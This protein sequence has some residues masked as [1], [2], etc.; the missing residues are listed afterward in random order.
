MIKLETPITKY[1]ITLRLVAESDAPFIVAIRNDERKKSFISKSCPDVDS[2]VQWI[3]DYKKRE[4]A[5]NE[6]YFI[7]EDETGEP[8]ATYRGYKISDDVVGGGSW[9]TKPDYEKWINA[10]KLDVLI[11]ELVFHKWGFIEARFDVRKQNKSV[12]RYHK[13]YHPTLLGENE[14]DFFFSL[15]SQQYEAACTE[16]LNSLKSKFEEEASS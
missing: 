14:E 12:V 11:K 4:A 7:A 3:R 5:G 10:I 15:S 8:F 2:Q 1:G 9:V 13:H 16:W 6:Y